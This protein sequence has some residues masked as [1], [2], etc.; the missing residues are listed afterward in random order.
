[1]G[2]DEF[3]SYVKEH[4]SLKDEVMKKKMTWQEIYENYS[5]SSEDP[6]PGYKKNVSNV[7]KDKIISEEPKT[8][9]KKEEKK[10][11]ASA[12]DMIK[13]VLGYVKKIDPDSIT[14]YVT[15][16]QKVLELLASFGAGATASAAS[17]KNTTDPLFD[18]KFD[19]WY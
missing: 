9:E 13:N 5:L 19:D 1:M 14:K 17:K 8:E 15:S 2:L 16:I 11:S 10:E 18:R 12:E 7:L 4:P 3:K 6:Y